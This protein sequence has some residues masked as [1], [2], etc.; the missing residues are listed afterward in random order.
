[1]TTR[2][3]H[4]FGLFIGLGFAFGESQSR[5]KYKTLIWELTI[6]IPFYNF[7]IEFIF[8]TKIK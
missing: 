1:M 8:P 3:K 2:V 7:R 4:E 6:V 5:K